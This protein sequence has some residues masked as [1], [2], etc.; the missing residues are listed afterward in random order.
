[1]Q[2]THP[3]AAIAELGSVGAHPALSAMTR[4]RQAMPLLVAVAVCCTPVRDEQTVVVGPDSTKALQVGLRP[5]YRF[6]RPVHG[7]AEAVVLIVPGCSGFGSKHYDSEAADLVSEGF[8]V[9][10][11]DYL[12]VSK[13]T[14]AC[15]APGDTVFPVP[16]STIAQYVLAAATDVRADSSIRALRVFAVGG[17]LGGGAVLAALSSGAHGPFPLDGVV[18]LYPQCRGVPE[19]RRPTPVLMLLG[20]LDNIA[21]PAV[22]RG[23]LAA[24]DS[25]VRVM[26]HTYPHAHHAFDAD[27]LAVV[28]EAR[29]EPTV[30]F[31]P[32]AATDAW[33]R[34]AQFLR[35]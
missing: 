30:G 6:R 24:K 5:Y 2:S 21:A 20:A 19:W 27:E 17:S 23:L 32:D 15:P 16:I 13:L 9:V 3:V 35:R 22:C 18:A 14:T 11:V 31:N 1:M 26:V 7:P 8:I 25:A 4:S 28:T 10:N 33:R 29:S 12:A 34:T